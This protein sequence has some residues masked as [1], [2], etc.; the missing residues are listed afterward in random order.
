MGY[1][2]TRNLTVLALMQIGV[3]VSATLIASTN[4]NVGSRVESKMTAV[5]AAVAAFGWLALP[6]PAAWFTATVY[7]LGRED[8]SNRARRTSVLAGVLLLFG[9]VLV[10]CCVGLLKASK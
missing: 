6:L 8:S 2:T 4:L 10:V 5:I 7:I 1:F 9:L 3:I